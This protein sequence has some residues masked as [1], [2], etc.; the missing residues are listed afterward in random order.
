MGKLTNAFK[1]DWPVPG[2][3]YSLGD[4]TFFTMK[5]VMSAKNSGGYLTRRRGKSGS[6]LPYMMLESITCSECGG[7]DP[8]FV[9]K[10]QTIM[11]SN[12][13]EEM[14]RWWDEYLTGIMWVHSQD[15]FWINET[16]KESLMK[17][18]WFL[19][20]NPDRYPYWSEGHDNR[21]DLPA[22]FN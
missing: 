4:P 18:P 2:H 9:R 22:Y 16:E 20:C 13:V 15:E 12:N 14:V 21:L 8:T 17:I 11:M 1:T 19:K 7:G 10:V 3:P 6:F 5:A